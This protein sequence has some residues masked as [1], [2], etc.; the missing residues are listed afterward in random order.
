[1]TD[2]NRGSVIGGISHRGAAMSG[3]VGSGRRVAPTGRRH[4]SR[5]R[6]ATSFLITATILCAVTLPGCGGNKA[7]TDYAEH[8]N[9]T[10]SNLNAKSTEL[11]KLWLVPVSDQAGMQEVLADYRKALAEAQETIDSTDP[12]EQCLDLETLLRKTVSS[13]RELADMYSPFADY[14]ARVGPIAARIG[15]I[16]AELETLLEDSDVP[17]GLAGLTEQMEEASSDLAA[18]VPP[19]L[20]QGMNDEFREFMGSLVATFQ[21]ASKEVGKDS[22]AYPYQDTQ[23]TEEDEEESA[24]SQPE[25]RSSRVEPLLEDVPDEWADFSAEFVALMDVALEVSGVKAK[26]AEV[27]NYVGQAWAQVEKLKKQYK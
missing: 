13:G 24:G 20:F 27:E 7:I 10:V 3:K 23:P 2:F 11:K 14:A 1:L 17:S 22:N 16:V 4:G 6:I 8:V 5:G 9:E 15:E 26:N 12:P 21:K 25:S 18:R 19:L